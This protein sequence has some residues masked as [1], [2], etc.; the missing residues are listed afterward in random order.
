MIGQLS[1]KFVFRWCFT[2]VNVADQCWSI[3]RFSK[4]HSFF[5]HILLLKA[6]AQRDH[7]GLLQVR[8]AR[9][10]LAWRPGEPGISQ[11]NMLSTMYSS[12]EL[13]SMLESLPPSTSKLQMLSAN[14]HLLRLQ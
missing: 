1:T 13:N 14:A 8:S 6:D 3:S 5:E 11:V 10:D 2:G 9:Y 7:A 4:Q 12:R